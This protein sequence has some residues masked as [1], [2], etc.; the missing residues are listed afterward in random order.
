MHLPF[1]GPIHLVVTDGPTG[2]GTG[3]QMA[4]TFMVDGSHVSSLTGTITDV[5][6]VNSPSD[7]IKLTLEL[8]EKPGNW[9]EDFA[10]SISGFY[11][12]SLCQG[13]F[14]VEPR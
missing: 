5:H 12:L 3:R 4:F 1:D 7:V 10:S 8:A 2:V 9:N 6:R 13:I 14:I 11:D